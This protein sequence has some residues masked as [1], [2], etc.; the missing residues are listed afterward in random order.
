[1]VNRRKYGVEILMAYEKLE[2]LRIDDLE[3]M[4]FVGS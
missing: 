1:M 4:K 2:Q 3:C